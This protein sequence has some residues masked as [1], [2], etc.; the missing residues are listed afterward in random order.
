MLPNAGLDRKFW[1]EAVTYAQ[2]L[3]N[4]STSSAIGGKT[5]LEVWFEKPVT[6]YDTLTSVSVGYS[7][8]YSSGYPSRPGPSL[9][10]DKLSTRARFMVPGCLRN[11][12]KSDGCDSRFIQEI[13]KVVTGN[14]N[15]AVLSISLFP[16]GID[17]RFDIM[18]IYGIG[19]IGKSTLVKTA[20]N[21]NFNKIDC[22]NF[23]ANVNKTSERHN[24]LHFLWPNFV[25]KLT[26]KSKR[27]VK[28]LCVDFIGIPDE[29]K[30]NHDL[31]RLES[32]LLE[33]I[34]GNTSLSYNS[35]LNGSDLSEYM[36]CL[37]EN[38]NDFMA[39][40]VGQFCLAVLVDAAE[41]EDD[42]KPINAKVTVMWSADVALKPYYVV[43]PSKHLPKE[44]D[45]DSILDDDDDDEDEEVTLAEIK[46][47]FG[48]LSERNGTMLQQCLNIAELKLPDKVGRLGLH[49]SEC[50][51]RL[52]PSSGRDSDEK[53]EK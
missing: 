14:L 13:V 41:S 37:G 21:L 12:N 3:I 42:I 26:K 34:N 38:L 19:G 24:G 49:G 50:P 45:D 5:P 2:H 9:D 48:D 16:V 18:S 28:R 22:S 23:L 17:S 35:E 6:D 33:V 25:V 8:L 39:N 4:H 44:N 10:Y 27:I 11:C 30:T 40:N 7:G 51:S 36:D 29:W 52:G 20:Y 32:Q 46:K 53:V 1:V 15:H 43:V 31:K 47:L